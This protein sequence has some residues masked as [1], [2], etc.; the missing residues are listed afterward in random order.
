MR[1]LAGLDE[2]AIAQCLAERIRPMSGAKTLVATL[3]AKDCH[4]VLVT[5]GFHQ[6]ADPIAAELGFAQVVAN[7]LE[8]QGGQLTG[9]LV[10][11]IVDSTVKKRTLREAAESHRGSSL[12][13][14]DGA[15]D[16]AMIAAATYG[17]AFHA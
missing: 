13:T 2:G 17:I 6:F 14:G 10:G 5:G 12:A 16:I 8:L 9:G 4:T 11:P 7:Q 1:L 3:K 15:N